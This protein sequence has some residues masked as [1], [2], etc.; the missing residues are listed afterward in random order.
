MRQTGGEYLGEGLLR[1]VRQNPRR[2]LRLLE[3]TRLRYAEG[4]VDDAGERCAGIS[5]QEVVE[6]G[7]WPGLLERATRYF[8]QVAV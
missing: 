4:R 7:G 1:G 5:P 3:V 8:G 6:R 2:D